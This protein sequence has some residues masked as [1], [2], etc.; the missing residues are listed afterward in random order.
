MTQDG[1]ALEAQ[2]RRVVA[3]AT[4]A[5]EDEEAYWA[6]VYALQ[7]RDP[8]M[9]WSLLVPFAEHHDPRLRALV[10]DVLRHL[11]GRP[12]PLL[13]ETLSLF[14]RMVETPQPPEVL[15]AIATAF[16]D[17]Q[18]PAAL[19]LLWPFVSHPDAEVRSAVVHGLLPVAAEAV[20]E[21]VVLSA[22]DDVDVRNWA[23]FG[24]G[25]QMCGARDAGYVESPERRAALWARRDDPDEDT[26][27][28]AL[29]GLA[30]LADE[31]VIP[32][33]EREL[34]TVGDYTHCVEAAETM[35]DPRLRDALVARRD[36]GDD[37]K[38][39]VAAIAACEP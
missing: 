7:K 31:R 14:A 10:P 38:K 13:A 9:V 18:H 2:F 3:E 20:A 11:G 17:L 33:L 28:E 5:G 23:T 8:A 34:A 26:R 27:G 15:T 12:Q 36:G 37:S 25:S 1:E 24:L 32:L 21:L 35:A 6:V 30:N 4:S 19:T 16:V 22:D 39:L 29:V